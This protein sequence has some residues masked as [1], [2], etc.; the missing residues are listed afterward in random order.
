[1]R[2]R[3]NGLPGALMIAGAAFALLQGTPSQAQHAQHTAAVAQS[4]NDK[5]QASALI[6][7]VRQ[8]TAGFK[9]VAQA[10]KAKYSLVLGC[11]TGP[12]AGAMGMHFLNQ[13]LLDQVNATGIFDPA[14]PQIILY[15]PNP[16]G[17][18]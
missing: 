8:A 9:D 7:A 14:S 16:D 13:N 2:N 3:K 6:E 4:P 11:V 17:S 1:M 18:L 12:D 15:E 10:E 5:D